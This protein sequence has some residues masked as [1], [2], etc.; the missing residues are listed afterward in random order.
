VPAPPLLPAS[1]VEPEL[2]AAPVVPAPPGEP[3][4][5][6][7]PELPPAPC[8]LEPVPAPTPGFTGWLSHAPAKH[9]ETANV[10]VAKS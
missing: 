3:A 7:L 8:V 2:L 4:L 1:P 6:E 5:P 9:S 10:A